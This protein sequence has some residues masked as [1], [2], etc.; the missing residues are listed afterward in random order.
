MISDL[1]F[2]ATNVQPN[3]PV[4]MSRVSL[5]LTGSPQDE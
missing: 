1:N 3:Q 4:F 2:Y 5:A